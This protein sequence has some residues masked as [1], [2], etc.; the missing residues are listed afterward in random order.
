MFLTLVKTFPYEERQ[1]INTFSVISDGA[2]FNKTNLDKVYQDYQEGFFWSRDWVN[3]GASKANLS[4]QYPILGI[5]NKVVKL[6]LDAGASIPKSHKFSIL[7]VDTI[8]RKCGCA[9]SEDMVYEDLLETLTALLEEFRTIRLFSDGG[10]KYWLPVSHGEF[11]GFVEDE[12]EEIINYLAN[13]DIEIFPANRAFINDGI[14]VIIHFEIKGCSSSKKDF[15]YNAI[16]VDQI[17]VAN[18]SIC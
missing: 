13:T 10:N 17:G 5:E 3:S 15:N 11:L 4:V 16:S 6:S 1:S 7:L 9:R 18:C 8:D 14:G 12:C 2:I